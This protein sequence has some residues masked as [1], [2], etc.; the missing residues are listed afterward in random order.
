[1]SHPSC[2]AL[3]TNGEPCTLNWGQ[4]GADGKCY[5]H[6]EDPELVAARAE[7]RHR[8]GE[9]GAHASRRRFHVMPDEVPTPPETLDDA[10]RWLSW[11]AVESASGRLDHKQAQQVTKAIEVWMRAQGYQQRIRELEKK[12]AA[13]AKPRG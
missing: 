12:I 7:S 4:F 8:A 11:T 13:L 2:P 6:S 1:V 5:W 9:L 10:L 3:K